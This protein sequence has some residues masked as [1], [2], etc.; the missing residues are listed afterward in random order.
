[1]NIIQMLVPDQYVF[2]GFWNNTPRWLVLH[3]TAGFHTA[4]EVAQYFQSGSNGLEVSSHFVV[5]QDGA[6]VQCVRETDGA[7]ANGVLEAGHDAW[8]SGNPNLVTYSVEHVDPASDNSTPLTAAQQ[9]A[10][11]QLIHDICTR[12]N[13][14][15]RPADATGGIT[16]HYSIDPQSRKE[17]PGN[18]PWNELWAYLKGAT[19]MPVPTGW[20]DTGT[21][22]IAPNKHYFVSGFRDHVLN[23]PSWDATDEPLEEEQKVSQVELHANSGPGTRQLTNGRLLIWTP[24]K[25]VKESACGAE[26]AKCYNIIASLEQQN[27]T[28][29][30]QIATLKATT[31]PA[32]GAIT[33]SITPL[34]ALIANAT[35]LE[36]EVIQALDVQKVTVQHVID[37]LQGK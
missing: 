5:G 34:Q 28:L 24:T 2:P 15:M 18:Y 6:A 26:I 31:P 35:L 11:F 29:S 17:C 19:H 3:K 30:A 27:K 36:Q 37:T 9:A 20:K 22:L 4:Q 25:G 10:S 7:G 23:A 32:S 16:G 13:I 33:S 14:P 8:W 1:M 12:H 21:E